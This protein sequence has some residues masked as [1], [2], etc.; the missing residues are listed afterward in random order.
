MENI[1]N[2]SKLYIPPLNNYNNNTLTVLYLQV[3]TRLAFLL[4]ASP[5]ELYAMHQYV[6]ESESRFP[7][8]ASKNNKEPSGSKA[9]RTLLTVTTGRPSWYHLVSGWGCPSDLQF[10]VAGSCSP[11]VMSVG[12]SMMRGARPQ[13]TPGNQNHFFTWYI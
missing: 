9:L 10:N 3:T 1:I 7:C 13:D 5:N 8:D 2:W 12:C 11:T 4:M 6:P